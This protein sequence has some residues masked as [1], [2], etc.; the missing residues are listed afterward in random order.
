MS[1]LSEKVDLLFKNDEELA[2]NADNHDVQFCVMMRIFI[3][4]MNRVI[5][6]LN[7]INEGIPEAQIPMLT[8]ASVNL[9]FLDFTK[10]RSRPLFSR[11]LSAWFMGED[12]SNLGFAEEDG[13]PGAEDDNPEG[14]VV[15]GGDYGESSRG[16]RV[17]GDSSSEEE[18][19]VSGVPPADD[20]GGGL[21]DGEQGVQ[22]QEVREGD[23]AH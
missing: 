9:E 11:Y 8:Y 3:S 2:R 19:A 5:D 14:A 16:D 15:F 13:T 23:E 22:V 4:T 20:S 6:R 10:F 21:E 1:Q 12:V 17:T 18:N 7:F